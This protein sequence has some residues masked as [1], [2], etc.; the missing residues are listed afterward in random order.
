MNTRAR[1]RPRLP[2]STA[3]EF[4]KST[5]SGTCAPR[6]PQ[7]PSVIYAIIDEPYE[8]VEEEGKE[9]GGGWKG[10]RE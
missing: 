3:L 6:P 5:S 2:G 1:P 4:E 7:G 9:K 10:E 8:G